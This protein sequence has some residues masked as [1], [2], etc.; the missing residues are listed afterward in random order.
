[1]S[2]SQW[3]CGDTR[4][5]LWSRRCRSWSRGWWVSGR[6]SAQCYCGPR[7]AGSS[8]R[9]CVNPSSTSWWF[10]RPAAAHSPQ[11]GWKH[12][13]CGAFVAHWDPHLHDRKHNEGEMAKEC[14]SHNDE[15]HWTGGVMTW[16][17]TP[18]FQHMRQGF[19]LFAP[20]WPMEVPRKL[21]EEKYQIALFTDA[22]RPS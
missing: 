4:I 9:L 12:P 7:R 15:K 22:K 1:M 10:S 14:V 8:S 17:Q 2:L 5:G 3:W 21:H 18:Y 16:W 19:G 11:C 13:E 6:Y 20:D